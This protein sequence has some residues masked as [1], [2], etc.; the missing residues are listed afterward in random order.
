MTP[1]HVWCSGDSFSSLSYSLH[2]SVTDQPRDPSP[3][4]NL[5]C[6]ITQ[7]RRA[8]AGFRWDVFTKTWCNY[9][10]RPLT[11]GKMMRNELLMKTLPGAAGWIYVLFHSPNPPVVEVG[12]NRGKTERE[13]EMRGGRKRT[14]ALDFNKEL[15]QHIAWPYINHAEALGDLPTG[16]EHSSASLGLPQDS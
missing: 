9:T 15:S 10:G 16:S 7:Q 13:G 14:N 3:P 2:P 12:E 11:L 8:G 5:L 6:K 4:N 1:L